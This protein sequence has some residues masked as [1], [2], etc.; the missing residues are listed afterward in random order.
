MSSSVGS[1]PMD[2]VVTSVGLL[3]MV[4]VLAVLVA[5]QV[6]LAS[7]P[8]PSPVAADVPGGLGYVPVAPCRVADTRVPSTPLTPGSTGVFRV[9]GNTSLAT[10][11]G[12]ATGCGVPVDAAAAEVTITAIDPVA[13]GFLRAFG[14]GSTPPTATFLNYSTGRSAT[15]T[16]TVPLV[17]AGNDGGTA[18]TGNAGPAGI[19]GPGG[20]LLRVWDNGTTTS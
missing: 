8:L 20:L 5:T 9:R 10:Q 17:A 14:A 19:S 4:V 6:T 16:G 7:G 15:N 3:R 1:K 18:S 2:R 12:S 13:N 11:G